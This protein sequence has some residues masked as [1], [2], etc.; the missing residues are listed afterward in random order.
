[1][2]QEFAMRLQYFGTK[3]VEYNQHDARIICNVSMYLNKKS[4]ISEFYLQV[5]EHKSKFS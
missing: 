2:F 3:G 4:F 1:M 5:A